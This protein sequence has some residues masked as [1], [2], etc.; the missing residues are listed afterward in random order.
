[1]HLHDLV[2]QLQDERKDEVKVGDVGRCVV[3]AVL[4]TFGLFGSGG[5]L[6]EAL[7]LF[8]RSPEIFEAVHVTLP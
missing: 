3:I 8:G 2:R 1:M 7:F 5:L 4:K 6:L